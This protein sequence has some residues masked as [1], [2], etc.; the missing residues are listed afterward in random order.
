MINSLTF[1]DSRLG[2][3]DITFYYLLFVQC[4]QS[5]EIMIWDV[6]LR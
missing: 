6:A 5:V 2:T 3:I 4:V 1:V